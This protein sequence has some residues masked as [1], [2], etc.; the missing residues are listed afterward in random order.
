LATLTGF[1]FWWSVTCCGQSGLVIALV[2][3]LGMNLF[4]YWNSDKMVPRM[5]NAQEVGPPGAR[6]LQHRPRVGRARRPADA[7]AYVMTR[8]NPTPSPPAA[9]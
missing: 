6:A 1:L 2:V 4:A 7:A 3:A 5:S 8:T 9:T